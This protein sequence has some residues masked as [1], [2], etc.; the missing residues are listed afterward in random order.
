MTPLSATVVTE[1]IRGIEPLG[2]LW[3]TRARARLDT[4]TKPLGSLGR[5]EDLAAQLAAN[6]HEH[7]VLPLNQ[8]AYVFAADHGITAEGVS[9]YPSAVTHQM[10]LNFQAGGASV[11]VLAR[12]HGVALHVVDVGIDADFNHIEGL[13]HHKASNGTKNM[14][15][16]AAMSDEEPFVTDFLNESL[17]IECDRH[18]SPRIPQ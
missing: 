10:V 7:L 9:A 18:P 17:T 11:N 6:R 15:R 4:L 16:D 5:R 1:S 13:L 2:A 3:R 14:L 8:A 12:L